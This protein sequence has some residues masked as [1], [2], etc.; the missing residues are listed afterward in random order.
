[1]SGPSEERLSVSPAG[2]FLRTSYR[3]AAPERVLQPADIP[4]SRLDRQGRCSSPPASVMSGTEPGASDSTHDSTT[5]SNF[6]QRPETEE[7]PHVLNID[8]TTNESLMPSRF[9]RCLAWM[10]SSKTST[11]LG[12]LALLL[13]IGTLYLT[14]MSYIITNNTYTLEKW[15]DCQDRPVRTIYNSTVRQQELT[16]CLEYYYRSLV[17][18]LTRDGL[19]LR[20][21]S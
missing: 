1:M 21:I 7:P 10:G 20:C 8:I 11:Q 19:Q 5:A 3:R 18:P 12:I 14:I 2:S 9:K 4:M 13:A 6:S 15:R 17:R 16:W